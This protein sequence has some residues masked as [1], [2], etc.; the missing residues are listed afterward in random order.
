MTKE[1]M[2]IIYFRDRGCNCSQSVFL[3]FCEDYNIKK[4]SGAQIAAPFGGG[5]GRQGETCGALT[6]ALMILGLKSGKNFL[7]DKNAKGE[8]MAIT[9]DFINKFKLAFG[10]IKCRDLMGCDVGSEAGQIYI[11]ENQ[12]HEK[13]C[14]KLVLG[15]VKMI[16]ETK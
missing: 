5:I 15:A 7:E 2:A 1:E 8:M 10:S 14:A 9:K 6:G 3:T 4:E 12:L 11:R 16:E 13:V